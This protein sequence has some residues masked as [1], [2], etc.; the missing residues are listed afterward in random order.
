MLMDLLNKATT[1]AMLNFVISSMLAMGTGLTVRQIVGPLRSARLVTL[2]FCK[3]C[4]DAAWRLRL[5]ER[6]EARRAARRGLATIGSGGW[7]TS[8]RAFGRS[9]SMELD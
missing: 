4:S 1:V 5:N 7:V 2:A 3:F 6:A 8:P 9:T